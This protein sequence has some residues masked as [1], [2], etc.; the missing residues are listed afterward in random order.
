MI[1]PVHEAL[2]RH[3]SGVLGRLYGLGFQ[4]TNLPDTLGDLF[5]LLHALHQQIREAEHAAVLLHGLA[6]RV[7]HLGDAIR[8]LSPW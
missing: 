1:L 6:H 2:R 4:I 7:A 5:D 8:R 3:L